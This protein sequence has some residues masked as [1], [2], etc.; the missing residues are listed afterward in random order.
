VYDAGLGEAVGEEA[1]TKFVDR[2]LNARMNDFNEA[3]IPRVSKTLPGNTKDPMTKI[4]FKDT[5]AIHENFNDN[6]HNN[7]DKKGGKLAI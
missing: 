6:K 3:W 7:K 2:Y 4:G 5:T 1:L